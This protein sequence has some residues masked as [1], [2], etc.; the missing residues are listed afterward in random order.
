LVVFFFVS[1]GAPMLLLLTMGA[2]GSEVNDGADALA[3][4]HQVEG[5]VDV[6]EPK[7]EGHI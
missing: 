5:L 1:K 7:L 4:V 3:L 2:M 6:T